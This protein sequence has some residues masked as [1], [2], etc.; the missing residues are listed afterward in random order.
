MYFSI[1]PKSVV[2]VYDKF[3]VN[4]HMLSVLKP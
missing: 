2:R 4:S 1:K 3:G